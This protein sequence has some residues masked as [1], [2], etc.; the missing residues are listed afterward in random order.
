MAQVFTKEIVMLHGASEGGWCF[1]PFRAVFEG[2]G[3]TCHT[4]D[5][6]GHGTTPLT[7][8]GGSSVWA[9]PNI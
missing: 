4:P 2:L 6:I 8:T 9:W 3:W 7:P 1:D 5:L